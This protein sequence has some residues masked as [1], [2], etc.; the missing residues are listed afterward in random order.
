VRYVFMLLAAL[1]WTGVWA[2]DQARVVLDVESMT[3][4]ACPITVKK[5]LSKVPGVSQVTV[6]YEHRT[7]AVSYDPAKTTTAELTKATTNAGYPSTV[8]K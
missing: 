4:A 3:C 8:R 6:D 5:A 7:A 2:G 1:S